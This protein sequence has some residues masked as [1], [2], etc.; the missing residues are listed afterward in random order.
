MTLL[1]TTNISSGASTVTIS[2]LPA[3]YSELYMTFH[4]VQSV[5][6]IY[7]VRLGMRFRTGGVVLSTSN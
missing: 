3:S 5:Y 2:G 7:G 6:S 1:N 4:N